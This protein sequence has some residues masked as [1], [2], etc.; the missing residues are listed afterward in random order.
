MA[1]EIRAYRK[2][3]LEGRVLLGC[4]HVRQGKERQNAIG[5][6]NRLSLD[7]FEVDFECLH[8]LVGSAFVLEWANERE[9]DKQVSSLP[10][11]NVGSKR[12]S[13]CGE[14]IPEI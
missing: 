5:L 11:S 3:V 4:G 9:R 6:R 1:N 2:Q 7:R 8:V 12:Q 13:E 14:G 10:S